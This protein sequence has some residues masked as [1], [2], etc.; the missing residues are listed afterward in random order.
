MTGASQTQRRGFA[1]LAVLWVLVGLSMLSLGAALTG[2]EALASARNR[3]ALTRAAWVAE[4]CAET[5]RAA[6]GE[7]LGRN[8]PGSAGISDP[9]HTWHALDQAVATSPLWTDAAAIC[10]LTLVPAG[11]KVNLSAAGDEQLRRLFGALGFSAEQ[12]D[13]LT[14]ALLDWED[15]DDIVRP[16]GAER[17][18]Y[19][20]ARRPVPRNGPIADLRELASVRGFESLVPTLDSVAW[21]EP[22]PL[23]LDRASTTALASLPGFSTEVVARVAEWRARGANDSRPLLDLQAL[24]SQ[25][26]GPAASALAPRVGELPVLQ[27]TAPEVWILTARARY[28]VPAVSAEIELRLVRAQDRAAVV[29]RRTRP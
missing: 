3:V 29:R 22:G 25:V 13:S 10:E 12:V 21:T 11:A 16:F 8:E 5:A 14:A 2:R 27:T 28:G 24:I 9:T 1:L 17:V 4:G 23:L 15:A 7:V 26:P 20:S 6:M 19:D 18:W